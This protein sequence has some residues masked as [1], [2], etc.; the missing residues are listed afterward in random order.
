MSEHTREPIKKGQAAL[1]ET[2]ELI[3][4]RETAVKG[5]RV[6]RDQETFNMVKEKNLTDAKFIWSADYE[7]GKVRVTTRPRV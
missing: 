6:D 2:R 7:N 5:R 1:T 3:T 4:D